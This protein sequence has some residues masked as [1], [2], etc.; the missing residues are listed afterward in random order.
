M[1][2]A[3]GGVVSYLATSNKHKKHK[4]NLNANK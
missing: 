4:N 3:T 2:S 1:D